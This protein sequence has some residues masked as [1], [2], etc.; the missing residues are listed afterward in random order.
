MIVSSVLH[1]RMFCAT[2]HSLHAVQS[3]AKTA[4]PPDIAFKMWLV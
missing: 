3:S 2:V 1:V 4:L